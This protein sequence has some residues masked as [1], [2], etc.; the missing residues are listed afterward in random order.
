[1][2]VCSWGGGVR[3]RRGPASGCC[4]NPVVSCNN[5]IICCAAITLSY[6]VLQ[7]PCHT[8]DCKVLEACN[9]M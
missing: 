8:S 1:M 9:P 3:T 4:N 2:K 7:Q 5:L 6:V